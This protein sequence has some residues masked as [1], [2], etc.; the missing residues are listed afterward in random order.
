M[1]RLAGD[2]DELVEAAQRGDRAAVDVLYRR[3]SKPVY[4]MV[5]RVVRNPE[6]ARELTQQVFVRVIEALPRYRQGREPFEGWLFVV[7][8][9]QALDHLRR[10]QHSSPE[11][12]ADIRKRQEAAHGAAREPESDW[13]DSQVTALLRGLSLAQRRVLT[14]RYVYDLTPA[15]IGEALG[16]TTDSVRHVQ[17]RGLRKLGARLAPSKGISTSSKGAT[18]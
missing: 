5:L 4:R 17:Q 16:F 18:S 8:R 9:N 15:E 7:A 13:T 11:D 6:D 2:V 14:L 12:P 3:F 1:P 10:K